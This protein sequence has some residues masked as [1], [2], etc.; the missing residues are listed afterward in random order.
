[1]ALDYRGDFT[2]TQHERAAQRL[3]D[4][5]SKNA[6]C[7]IKMGQM[8]SQFGNLVHPA[9]TTKFESMLSEAPQMS[10]NEVQHIL[11]EDLKI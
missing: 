7:Y 1:M 2:D 6:G 8:I 10:F 11:K 5:F 4:C 9:Y 3:H